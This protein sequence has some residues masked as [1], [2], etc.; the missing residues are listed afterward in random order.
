MTAFRRNGRGWHPQGWHP[1]GSTLSE[2]DD[3]DVVKAI[4]TLK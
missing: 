3:D 4:I 2:V 1:Q